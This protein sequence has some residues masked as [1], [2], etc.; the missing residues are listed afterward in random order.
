LI[1]VKSA[2][3]KVEL[4]YRGFCVQIM[5]NSKPAGAF[6]A[7]GRP[8][9]APSAGERTGGHGGARWAARSWWERLARGGAASFARYH[10]KRKAMLAISAPAWTPPK[11]PANDNLITLFVKDKA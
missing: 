4:D 9:V 7:P 8:E 6:C 11:T 10:R 5:S 2:L 3:L 1:P